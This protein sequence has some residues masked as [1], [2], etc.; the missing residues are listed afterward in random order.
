MLRNNYILNEIVE[1]LAGKSK[2]PWMLSPNE[3][4]HSLMLYYTHACVQSTYIYYKNSH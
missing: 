3:I 2:Q 1:F 4:K